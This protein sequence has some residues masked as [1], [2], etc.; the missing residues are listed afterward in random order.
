MAVQK[1][2]PRAD[3]PDTVASGMKHSRR[4]HRTES[5]GEVLWPAEGDSPPWGLHRPTA[6]SIPRRAGG[7]IDFTTVNDRGGKQQI[8]KRQKKKFDERE[9]ETLLAL[10]FAAASRFGSR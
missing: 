3:A 10:P 9:T 6:I 7:V 8:T 2:K 1:K 5:T 4:L